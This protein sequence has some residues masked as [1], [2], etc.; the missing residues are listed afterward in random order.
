MTNHHIDLDEKEI[1]RSILPSVFCIII[2]VICL[3]S[4]SLAWF[5]AS[6]SNNGTTMQPGNF[7]VSATVDGTALVSDTI[8]AGTH[9]LV[10][11]ASGTAT[12]GYAVINLGD[13]AY[14]TVSF[15]PDEKITFNVSVIADSKFSVI[16][17]WGEAGTDVTVDDGSV[18]GDIVP[19][20]DVAN[21]PRSVAAN[22]LTQPAVT[23]TSPVAQT[24]AV[25]TTAVSQ[26]QTTTKKATTQKPVTTAKPTSAQKPTTV[27]TTTAPKTEL[28]QAQSNEE[29]NTVTQVD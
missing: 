23:T 11:T 22:A 17:I 9:T 1:K 8:T 15:K 25:A 5:E 6:I 3:I 26:V 24:S 21:L 20:A 13:T 7:S 19:I 27:T 12:K 4:T 18:I 2:C 16:G 14:H 28:T 10:L 29:T